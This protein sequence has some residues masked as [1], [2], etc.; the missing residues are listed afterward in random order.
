METLEKAKTPDKKFNIG[1]LY[2][3]DYLADDLNSILNLFKSV[4]GVEHWVG[5]VGLGVCGN[6]IEHIDEPAISALIGYI[7]DEEFCIFPPVRNESDAA[8]KALD[9]WMDKSSPMMV[10]THGDPM[11]ETNPAHLL[12]KLDDITGGYVV[13]GMTSSRTLNLQIAG[14]ICEDGFGGVAFSDAILVSSML[15][16]GCKKAGGV[17]TITRGNEHTILEIDER[18]ALDVFEDDIRAMT[19]KQ[20]DM[21]PNQ[22]NI[23]DGSIKQKRPL[24][25]YI[26]EKFKGE[27]LAAMPVFDSDQESYL[28]RN[29]IAID[30]DERTLDIAHM[31]STGDRIVFMYRDDASV[32]NDLCHSLVQMRERIIREH[33][34][35][36]PKA[37]I[38]ISCLARAFTDFSCAEE[39]KK[40][41]KE[42]RMPGGEMALIHDI[43]GDVPLTGFY[44]AGEINCAKQYGYSGILILFL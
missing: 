1:F 37:G 33:G 29:I 7:P 14:K 40:A 23:E 21:D 35:F 20:T 28:V 39:R 4:L 11:T 27:V 38:Y 8:E 31:I 24:P 2:V 30:E 16:Q 26:Q 5:S 25:E 15:S 22:H 41:G 43:I 9:T 6:S 17:H 44:A 12:A 18:P 42:D 32:R 19:I 34:Y 10:F 13:G 36:N 3:S